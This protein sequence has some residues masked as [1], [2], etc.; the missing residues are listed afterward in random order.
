MN[1]QGSLLVGALALVTAF[2]V[3]AQTIDPLTNC[4]PVSYRQ[5]GARGL[6]HLDG[7]FVAVGGGG[8]TN[9]AV[10]TNGLNWVGAV[11]GSLSNSSEVLFAVEAA[12]GQFV[13]V[14]MPS[15]IIL[16]SPDGF[17]WT[18]RSWRNGVEFWAVTYGNGVFVAIG[19][20]PNQRVV[21]GLSPDGVQWEILSL[22]QFH[23]T[24]RNIAY[25]NG[26]FVAAG[27]PSSLTSTNG[28]DWVA[29]TN[30]TAQGAAFGN[31]RFLLTL[32]TTGHTSTN[33]LDWTPVTFAAA[34]DP[35]LNYY[36]AGFGNGLFMAGGFAAG[37]GVLSVLGDGAV[38][39]LPT[40]SSRIGFN[41]VS[42]GPIRDVIFA[43]GRY[44]L[45]DQ[46][47]VIWRSGAV[48]PVTP[49]RVSRV[50][51]S[52]AQTS[53]TLSTV[54]GFRYTVETADEVDATDWQP[55]APSGLPATGEELQFIDPQAD[56]PVRF[57]RAR[58]E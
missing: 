58:T 50:T 4:Q 25:G 26:R 32:G 5:I 43:E 11:T 39:T 21:V 13:A 56:R 20:D 30:L 45:A 7:R 52:N 53:L 23:T 54:P 27:G 2:G 22:P 1:P 42:M 36:S 31:G 15:G 40:I 12:V 19:F 24:P 44:Y 9:V 29:L 3:Q 35:N 8:P 10:S 55:L 37:S 38:R 48:A 14:G 47:G 28:R 51:R 17:Q 46:N 34:E 6:A 18:R 49:P 16:N 41:V 33:G 57:Y